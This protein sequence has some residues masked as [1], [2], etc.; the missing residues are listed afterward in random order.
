MFMSPKYALL[1]A[2]L[3]L[4]GLPAAAA[5]ET[6]GASAPLASLPHALVQCAGLP[7]I[8]MT[9]DPEQ[10]LPLHLVASLA[11]GENVAVL[12][13]DEGYTARIRTADGQEGFVARTY[14]AFNR[15][16]QPV[17]PVAVRTT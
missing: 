15:V 6:P 4:A 3:L 11:C 13:D 17:A 5:E 12:A 2:G 8:P 1:A 10:A 9:S 7:G 14:L 16:S